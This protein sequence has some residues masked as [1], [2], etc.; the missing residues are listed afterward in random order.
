[1]VGSPVVVVVGNSSGCGGEAGTGRATHLLCIRRTEDRHLGD[2]FEFELQFPV[3]GCCSG[4]STYARA[5][6]LRRGKEREKDR[7]MDCQTMVNEC[8]DLP[9]GKTVSAGVR[10]G[11]KT[12]SGQT[13]ER[14]QAGNSTG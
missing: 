14:S 10:P 7:R 1:M 3:P 2:P 13:S 9:Q 12:A 4:Y 8:R 6:H 11:V 5:L